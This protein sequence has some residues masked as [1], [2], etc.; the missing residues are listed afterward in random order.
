[1]Q[2]I[3]GSQSSS[4]PI[5]VGVSTKMYLGYR[6]SLDWLERLRHEVDTRPALA[7]GRVV[8]FVIPS[9]PVLP[10]AARLLAGTPLLLGAQNCGWADGPW[11]GEV[12]PSMLAELGVR[13][14]EIGHAERLRHFYED[15]AKVVFEVQSE[16]YH[17]ALCDV[18]ADAIRR[19]KLEADG[20]IV[21]EVWDTDWLGATK[22]LDTHI[23]TLRQKLDDPAAITTLRG[24]GYRLD[25]A[26]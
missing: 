15:D 5:L 22:T 13:L 21:R 7:A 16:L 8:P 18:E 24:F 12:A 10:E 14:V 25:V 2:Q 26:S 9:F 23:L 1:M 17:W 11:T 6:D 19:E 4:N 3:P 20:F